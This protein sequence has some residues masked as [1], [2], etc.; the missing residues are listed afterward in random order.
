M[1]T[2]NEKLQELNKYGRLH[3]GRKEYINILNGK[4][5]TWKSRCLAM[6]YD[7][8][9]YFADGKADC[10]NELCPLYKGMPYR[11]VA[12][13]LDDLYEN[14]E[15]TDEEIDVCTNTQVENYKSA[16]ISKWE[17]KKHE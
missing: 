17:S 12:E 1:M 16:V 5:S 7:C 13:T 9:G 14:D 10:G 3:Q 11:R 15:N 2:Q 6:C 8:M 4:P